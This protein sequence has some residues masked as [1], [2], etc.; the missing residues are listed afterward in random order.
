MRRKHVEIETHRDGGGKTE[1][2]ERSARTGTAAC[3]IN[4]GADAE[5]CQA[6][7]IGHPEKP[8]KV[9][10]LEAIELHRWI[11]PLATLPHLRRNGHDVPGCKRVQ[12]LL[13]LAVTLDGIAA[14]PGDPLPKAHTGRAAAPTFSILI[15][16]DKGVI[17]EE[18]WKGS[19]RP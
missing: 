15:R 14:E 10:H 19:I 16:H 12:N 4:P 3:A 13:V 6:H 9:A 18:A 2:G 11:I 5:I 17:Q 8:G 7:E 1:E